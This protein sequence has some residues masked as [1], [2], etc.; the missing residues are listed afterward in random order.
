MQ[1]FVIT[2]VMKFLWRAL[3][4]TTRLRVRRGFLWTLIQTSLLDGCVSVLQTP[5]WCARSIFH[6]PSC[7]LTT[8]LGSFFIS[9][10]RSFLLSFTCSLFVRIRALELEILPCRARCLF[11]Y[12][13]VPG[14]QLLSGLSQRFY[15]DVRFI[16]SALMGLLF[17]VCQFFIGRESGRKRFARLLSADPI[18]TY[19][20]MFQRAL[21]PPPVVYDALGERILR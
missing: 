6:A 11:S 1:V 13:V 17:M 16:L 3:S 7:P 21:M 12:G 4:N 15:E 8:L 20:L 9:V 10:S 5:S 19:L 18:A 14:Y 2:F